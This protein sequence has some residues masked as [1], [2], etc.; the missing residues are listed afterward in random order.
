[1]TVKTF[2]WVQC[3]GLHLTIFFILW[4]KIGAKLYYI[5]CTL[6]WSIWRISRQSRGTRDKESYFSNSDLLINGYAMHFLYKKETYWRLQTTF[7]NEAQ[8][9]TDIRKKLKNGWVFGLGSFDFFFVFELFHNWN[10]CL[11]LLLL[12]KS[13][14]KKTLLPNIRRNGYRKNW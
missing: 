11:S 10:M 9:R 12:V 7:S 6:H 13:S 1:M 5:H 8:G 14:E 3:T 2:L 4:F